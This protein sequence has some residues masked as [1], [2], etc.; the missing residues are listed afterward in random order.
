MPPGPVTS[1]HVVADSQKITSL[2]VSWINPTFNGFSDIAAFRVNLSS[3]NSE[4]NYVVP[5]N[6]TTTELS[7]PNLSPSTTY[8]I[9][10]FVRNEVQLEGEVAITTGTTDPLRNELFYNYNTFLR[11]NVAV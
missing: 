7:V 11:K 10:V 8:T 3:E 2:R 1:L 5:G 6:Q 4:E 9:Q